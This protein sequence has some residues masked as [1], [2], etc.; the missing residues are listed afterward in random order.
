MDTGMS[1]ISQT[2]K[3]SAF[4]EGGVMATRFCHGLL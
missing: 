1:M 2:F 4:Q 3:L